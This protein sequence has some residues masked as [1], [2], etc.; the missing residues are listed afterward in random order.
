[1]LVSVWS[2]GCRV[3][4]FPFTWCN[5]QHGDSRILARLD[6]CLLNATCQDFHVTV[7]H[8][9]RVNSNHAS[10]L[11]NIAKPVDSRPQPFKFLDVWLED[12]TCMQT[13]KRKSSWDK[14]VVDEGD[15]SFRWFL[16]TKRLKEDLR[17]W[18]KSAFGDI[19]ETICRHPDLRPFVSELLYELLWKSLL[20]LRRGRPNH[21]LI[22]Q[23]NIPNLTQDHKSIQNHKPRAHCGLSTH[24]NRPKNHATGPA[25]GVLRLTTTSDH[26]C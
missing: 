25:T 10:L 1:M 23:P 26:C 15:M 5:N 7:T 12:E 6:R 22:N 24:G 3:C 18:N 4:G 13:I 20:Q 2:C 16:K 19:Y 21:L 8:L 17:C 14:A 9:A 11:L